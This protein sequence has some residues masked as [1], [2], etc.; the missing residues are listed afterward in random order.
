MRKTKHGN[1]LHG[2]IPKGHLVSTY[3]NTKSEFSGIITEEKTYVRHE[4]NAEIIDTWVDGK[5]TNTETT[6][7]GHP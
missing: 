3:W 4:N 7:D 1:A 5:L 2:N 6:Y